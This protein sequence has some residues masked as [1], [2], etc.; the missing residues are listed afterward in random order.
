MLINVNELDSALKYTV[1]SI[2][3]QQPSITQTIYKSLRF[4]DSASVKSIFISNTARRT[5]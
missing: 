4:K 3:Y 5:R 2:I 1:D